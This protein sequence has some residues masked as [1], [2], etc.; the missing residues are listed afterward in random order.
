MKIINL[1]TEI[2]SLENYKLTE[3]RSSEKIE[4]LAAKF[5]DPRVVSSS[6]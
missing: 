2:R 4:I 6:N 3:I 5:S 1:R